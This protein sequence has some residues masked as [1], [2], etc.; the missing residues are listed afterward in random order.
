MTVNNIDKVDESIKNR[1][2][3]FRYVAEFKNP[4]FNTRLKILENKILAEETDGL[5]LDQV[6]FEKHKNYISK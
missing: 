4:D 5:N 3:R 2:S 1:P 6:F